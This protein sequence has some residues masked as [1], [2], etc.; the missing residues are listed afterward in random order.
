MAFKE[1]RRIAI[2]RGCCYILKFPFRVFLRASR[3][4]VENG[5]FDVSTIEVSM[6]SGY[7]TGL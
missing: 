7:V 6:S 4:Y 2:G 5:K 1:I 3:G